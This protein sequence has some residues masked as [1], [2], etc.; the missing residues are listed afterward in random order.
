MIP[1]GSILAAFAISGC[2]L[3]LSCRR[4]FRCEEAAPPPPA[5]PPPQPFSIV[6]LISCRVVLQQPG[7]HPVAWCL[8]AFSVCVLLLWI[9]PRILEE[10]QAAGRTLKFG[11]NT[12]IPAGL[13]C[14]GGSV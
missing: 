9:H 5:P 6:V 4:S 10:N 13:V 8:M 12:H 3:T 11:F 1:S 2:T 7:K 14:H